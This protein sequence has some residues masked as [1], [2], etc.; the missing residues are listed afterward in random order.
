[1]IIARKSH[2]G[3]HIV[4]ASGVSALLQIKNTPFKLLEEIRN[5]FLV[6]SE[7]SLFVGCS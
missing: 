7:K 1:M 5:N 3:Y 6:G 2:A 4:H